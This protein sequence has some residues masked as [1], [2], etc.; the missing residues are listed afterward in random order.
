MR[1]RRLAGRFALVAV[2]AVV[3]VVAFAVW[4]QVEADQGVFPGPIQLS[5]ILTIVAAAWSVRER[6]DGWAFTATA[7]AMGT[8][9]A[10]IFIVLYPM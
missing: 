1:A 4:T 8:T 5:G 3:A 2:V 10:S 9:V 6:N 7:V